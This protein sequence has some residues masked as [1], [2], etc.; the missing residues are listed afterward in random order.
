MAKLTNRL[1]ARTVA[2]LTEPGLHSDG[3]GLVLQITPAGSKSWIFRYKVDGKIKSMGLGSANALTIA[4][5]RERAAECRELRA[6]GVD[7]LGAKREAKAAVIAEAEAQ[8]AVDAAKAKTFKV[9]A[10]AF[11]EANESTWKNP[12]HRQQWKN[13]LATYVYGV[14]GS[15]PVAEVDTQDVTKVLLPIWNTKPETA[16]RVRGRIETI[17]SY[18]KVQGYRAGENPAAWRGHLALTLPKRS[19]VQAVKHH[20]ALPYTELPAFIARLQEHSGLAALAL[21]L[22]RRACRTRPFRRIM[23]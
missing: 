7:P 11:I 6:A 19:K 13:T 21:E 4:K 2:A 14:F 10:E 9:C 5:A 20:A 3:D 1:T 23:N 8:A 15:K 17:L 22:A 12:K 16:V 18:A